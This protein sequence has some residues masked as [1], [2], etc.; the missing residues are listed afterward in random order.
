MA[1][2]VVGGSNQGIL[3]G[4]AQSAIVRVRAGKWSV[5]SGSFCA[6][7]ESSESNVRFLDH[8]QQVGCP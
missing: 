2:C 8:W 6:V 1:I 4:G 3:T 5:S 7:K